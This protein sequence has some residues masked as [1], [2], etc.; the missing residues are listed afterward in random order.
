LVGN[1]LVWLQ[2]IDNGTNRTW[3]YGYD[4]YN[5]VDLMTEARTT[6][7]TAT[8][9]GF[10]ANDTGNGVDCGMTLMSASP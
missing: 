3:S 9:W 8:K 7:L 6:F 4:G 2:Y 5:F 1:G 10:Y